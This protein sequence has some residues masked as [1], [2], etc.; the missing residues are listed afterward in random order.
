MGENYIVLEIDGEMSLNVPV[1]DK[2]SWVSFCK[3]AADLTMIKNMY[4]KLKNINSREVENVYHDLKIQETK[5]KLEDLETY[6]EGCL[7]AG[8]SKDEVMAMLLEAGWPDEIVI[9]VLDKFV[10]VN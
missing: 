7:T 8:L 1:K 3:L 6:V 9:H 5:D 10:P 4:F 2:M